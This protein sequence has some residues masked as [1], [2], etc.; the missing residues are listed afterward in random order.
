LY[1]LIGILVLFIASLVAA[2]FGARSWHWAHVVLVVVIF[3][4][5]AGFLILSA[6]VLRVNAVLRA[7]AN[8]LQH[9]LDVVTAKNAALEKGSRD[10]K[11]IG[12]LTGDEVKIPEGAEQIPSVD[13]LQHD[14]SLIERDRGRVWRNVMPAGVDA[15]TETVKATVEAPQPAAEGAQAT[16]EAPKP[17]A[18]TAGPIGINKDSI[19]FLFEQGEPANPDSTKGPQYLGEFRV[20]AVSDKQVTMVAVQLLD[21]FELKRLQTS[22]GPWA[23]HESMPVD[24]YKLFDGLTEKQLREWLPEKSVQ[25][26]LRHGTTKE[27]DDDPIRVVG[28]DDEGKPVD[29]KDM[30]KAVK[31]LYQ[32]RL[33]DYALEFDE[34]AR[35]RIVLL[36]NIAGVTKDNERLKLALASAKQLQAF[37]EEEQQKLG[38]DLAGI[39]KERAMIEKHLA[40]VNQELDGYRQDL[41]AKLDENAR[42]AEQLGRLEA[43]R[44]DMNGKKSS[45]I[46]PVAPLALDTGK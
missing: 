35:D 5:T 15:K 14:L 41:A 13:D 31:I 40:Q 34:L 7:Q 37:R 6:E 23:L 11:L 32:R 19:L 3:V 42:L 44:Q 26:Y 8:K 10:P 17:A 28:L 33:R 25:E 20:T 2:Y 9:D 46:T 29:P 4:A 38:V 12:E 24:Q 39:T 30:S 27:A 45:D 21:D 1:I 36:A 18:A 16:G 43:Q 22:K